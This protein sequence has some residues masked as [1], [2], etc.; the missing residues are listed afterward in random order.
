MALHRL[1]VHFKTPGWAD[2]QRLIGMLCGMFGGVRLHSGEGYWMQGNELRD[3]SIETAICYPAHIVG[4]KSQM[5]IVCKELFSMVDSPIIQ[6]EIDNEVVTVP[7]HREM[8][9]AY[10]DI[11]RFMRAAY[12]QGQTAEHGVARKII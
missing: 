9:E 2:Q 12:P 5:E 11:A 7:R 10:M 3:E 4:V 1:V 6:Y 8:T